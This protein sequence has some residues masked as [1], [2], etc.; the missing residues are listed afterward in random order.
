MKKLAID[1]TY[2][3]VGGSLAQIKEMINNI[4]YYRFDNVIF[5][6]SNDNYLKTNALSLNKIYLH[7][8]KIQDQI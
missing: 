2:K 7:N 4:D 8:E 1:L 5:Y 6:V 3:P